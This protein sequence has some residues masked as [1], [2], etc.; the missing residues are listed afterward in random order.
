VAAD[1]IA[2]IAERLYQHM[3]A[4]HPQL[5][6]GKRLRRFKQVTTFHSI[7]T[8]ATALGHHAQNLTL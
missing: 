7:N 8:A 1:N 6:D 4:N 5:L 2:E 3:F